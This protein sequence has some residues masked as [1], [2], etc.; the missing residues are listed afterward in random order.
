MRDLL[1]LAMQ[2]VKQKSK[3]T[4]LMIINLVIGITLLLT[5]STTMKLS[6]STALE[7]SSEYVYNFSLNF[8]D[9][10]YEIR[11]LFRSPPLAYQDATQLKNAEL[12]VKHLSLNYETRFVIESQETDETRP[13]RAPASASD[14][15]YF[16][17]LQVPFVYGQPWLEE[18]KDSDV[19]VIDKKVNDQLFAGENSV[20]QFV[21]VNRQLLKVVGV[22][23]LSR[24]KYRIQNMRFSNR[25]NDLAVIPMETAERMHLPRTGFMPCQTKEEGLRV[26]FRE[27]DVQGLKSAECGYLVTWLEFDRDNHQQQLA[28]VTKWA[29]NY[30]Q[31]QVS[32]GR[33]PH[34]Q[35]FALNS[36]E[37]LMQELRRFL[38]WETVYL[39]F[40][41]LL[42]AICLVNTVGIL[43]AKYQAKNK[44]VSLYRALGASRTY[45]MKIHLI[46]ISI[47]ALVAILA[48]IALAHLGLELMF[49]IA[50]YQSDYVGDPSIVKAIYT[51]DY[52]FAFSTGL[53]IYGAI[54]LAG[55]YPVIR[56]S[57]IAPA[58]Q[59]RG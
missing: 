29:R 32:L 14:L 24:Y 15:D 59:L 43:L 26:E 2:G 42:F 9:A 45:I 18:Q 20:G 4:L 21:K 30:A 12:D 13:I 51:I 41:Y 34:E 55:L 58:A 49:Q 6:S 40:A 10:E 17:I 3:L 1:Q 38:R 25:Y 37:S 16:K 28:E 56:I 8:M 36:L 23:D 31:Q 50:R 19:I 44:L 35:K 33:F 47:I 53:F 5:M 39:Q 52:G 46:E 7:H 57:G 27:S 11:N 54:L 22:M 48:G